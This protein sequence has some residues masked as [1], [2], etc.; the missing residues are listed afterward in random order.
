MRRLFTRLAFPLTAAT[1]VVVGLAAP[2]QAAETKLSVTT[3][4]TGPCIGRQDVTAARSASGT[5]TFAWHQPTLLLGLPLG[6]S[7]RLTLRWRNTTT[8]VTGADSFDI[9]FGSVGC[10]I[11]ICIAYRATTGPGR[12]TADLVS[13]LPHQ[14]GKAELDVTD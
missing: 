3:L 6:C 5:V 9:A 11:P 13:D 7:A 8:G 12:I 1:A 4:T 2:A 14:P 10:D